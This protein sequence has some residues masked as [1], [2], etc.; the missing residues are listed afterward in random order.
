MAGNGSAMR[1]EFEGGDVLVFDR[2][3]HVDLIIKI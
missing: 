1:W 3:A 2:F